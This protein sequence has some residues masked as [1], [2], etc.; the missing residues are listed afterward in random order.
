MD[1]ALHSVQKA[2]YSRLSSDV[3]LAAAVVGVFDDVPEGTGFPYVE[4]GDTTEIPF[5]VF[6]KDGH[7]QTL[8]LHIWSQK[9]GMKEA[10]QIQGMINGLLHG[11]SLTVDNHSTVLLLHDGTNSQLDPDGV[12]RHLSVRFRCVVQDT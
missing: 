6:G 8:T 2:V 3:T 11:Y 5:D 10:Q 4:L 9:S 12:T 7:E 1:S